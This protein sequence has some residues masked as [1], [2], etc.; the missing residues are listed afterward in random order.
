MKVV[1]G[2]TAFK[3]QLN[4]KVL[5]LKVLMKSLRFTLIC[6][7]STS[8]TSVISESYA[9][10]QQYNGEAGATPPHLF[11]KLKCF[12]LPDTNV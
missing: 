11:V 4:D 10:I 7:F 6:D 8:Q 9:A 5:K 2:Q 3:L 12:Y 1:Y